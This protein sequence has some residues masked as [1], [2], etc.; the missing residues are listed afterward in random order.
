[1]AVHGIA[2]FDGRVKNNELKVLENGT[3]IETND[4]NFY[5]QGGIDLR[6]IYWWGSRD[7][8]CTNCAW[9]YQRQLIKA[10]AIAGAGGVITG[11]FTF[12]AGTIACA[13]GALYMGWQ[14]SDV[15]YYNSISSNGIIL[16]QN[17]W[18][19]YSIKNQ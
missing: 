12:G 1:M 5:L 9:E 19:T 15:G 16:D 10:A 8:M 14:A 7:Y 2:I 17:Y 6:E 4:S 13:A 3:I 18:F 11:I